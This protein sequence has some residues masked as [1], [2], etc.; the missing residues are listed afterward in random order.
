MDY[1]LHHADLQKVEDNPLFNE[2]HPGHIL[3]MNKILSMI[4]LEC[5]YRRGNCVGCAYATDRFDDYRCNIQFITGTY[6]DSWKE[7][8]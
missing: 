4:S 6:P 5:K 1:E 8:K 2:M 7:I 3:N